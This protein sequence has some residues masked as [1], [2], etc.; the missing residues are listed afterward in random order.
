MEWKR[1]DGRDAGTQ[2]RQ[3]KSEQSLI[4]RA[5]GSARVS[6]GFTSVLVAVYVF[7]FLFLFF[8]F[9]SFVFFFF[10]TF[11]FLFFPLTFF[12]LF[13]P[14][15][16]ISYGPIEVGSREEK[17]DAATILVSFKSPKGNEKEE[18]KEKCVLLQ[19]SLAGVIISALHPR[20]SIDIQVQV[21][22]DDGGLLAVAV[23]AVCMALVDAGIPMN[24]L[25][26]GVSSCFVPGKGEF[27]F[28]FF[29]F[30]LIFFYLSFFFSFWLSLI[31][32]GL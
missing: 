4:N 13:S 20:T 10:L 28:F 22:R 12:F 18:E 15:L 29:F 14:S 3:I 25:I 30:F 16:P 31:W 19:R 8:S 21:L 11:F 2:L 1:G 5:D 7:F 24:H 26:A 6:Q 32:F 17:L 9:S 23:N 27:F